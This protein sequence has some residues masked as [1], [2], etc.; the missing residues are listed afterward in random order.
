MFLHN[1]LLG[2]CWLWKLLALLCGLTLLLKLFLLF[3]VLL[4]LGVRDRALALYVRPIASV[5]WRR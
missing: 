1:F 4:V 5:L 2:S 3:L